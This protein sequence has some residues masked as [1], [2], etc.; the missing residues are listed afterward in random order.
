[1]TDYFDD[2]EWP[3]S[4]THLVSSA[5]ITTRAKALEAHGF[6]PGVGWIDLLDDAERLDLRAYKIE[7]DWNTLDM[8]FMTIRCW[9]GYETDMVIFKRAVA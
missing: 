7:H 5:E 4:F 6:R 9:F 8:R 1:M 2:T 3:Y